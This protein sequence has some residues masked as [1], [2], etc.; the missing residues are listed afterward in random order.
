MR[1][2]Q[3]Y[4]A[5]HQL[6]GFLVHRAW[7]MVGRRQ[8]DFSRSVRINSSNQLTIANL[9]R[10][11]D[12][13]G[14]RTGRHR[15]VRA[16]QKLIRIRIPAKAL[17]DRS[18]SHKRS[19]PSTNYASSSFQ[20]SMSDVPRH[21]MHMEIRR[22][23][24]KSSNIT[25]THI[26]HTSFD[27]H[28]HANATAQNSTRLSP[29]VILRFHRPGAVSFAEMGSPRTLISS[30]KKI[31]QLRASNWSSRNLTVVVEMTCAAKAWASTC[32]TILEMAK[33]TKKHQQ[34]FPVLE[35]HNAPLLESAP[36]R[37]QSQKAVYD[38]LSGIL[39][40]KFIVEICKVVRFCV[41]AVV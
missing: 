25:I 22:S 29:Q 28:A 36:V 11:V 37:L 32:A 1:R 3:P 19:L 21:N 16:L 15:S 17:H 40:G 18:E 8:S 26:D 35:V 30:V 7:R 9:Y 38:V 10:Y 14:V 39:K 12:W 20:C 24:C 27:N 2:T 4:R 31:P 13:N 5:Y 33:A 6:A 23:A 41:A 34:D